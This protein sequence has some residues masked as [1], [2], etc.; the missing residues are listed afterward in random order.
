[1]RERFQVLSMQ[2][3]KAEAD[4][5]VA[6][7]QA[8]MTAGSYTS[9]AAL[10]SADAYLNAQQEPLTKMLEALMEAQRT[11]P[12]DLARPC[13]QL[14]NRLRLQQNMIVQEQQKIRKGR[15]EAER[16]EKER[17]LEQ[18]DQLQLDE[19]LPE[20]TAKAN[21]AEDAA[22]K[23]VITSELVQAA[24][25]DH[26]EAMQ[27]V[28]Q[29]EQ[30]VAEA[31]RQ[32]AEAR[33][34]F[35][36]KHGV[37]RQMGSEKARVRAQAELTK[38]IGQLQEAQMKIKPLVGLRQALQQRQQAQ[39]MVAEVMEKL[40][41]AKLEC[42][43]AEE[44]ANA[45]G[46]G[47]NSDEAR[48]TMDTLV[49]KAS[50]EIAAVM[51]LIAQKKAHATGL[52]VG[53]LHKLEEQ[54]KQAADRMTALKSSYKELAEK[55]VWQG[56][57]RDA[58]GRVHTVQESVS[59]AADAEGPF[60]LG[61]DELPLDET[62]AALRDCESSA[63]IA[64]T[65]AS[66]TK[67]FI[68]TKLVDAKR[69]P[70]SISQEISTKLKQLQGQLEVHTKRLNDLKAKTAERKKVALMR[71]AEVLVSALEQLTTKLSEAAL[72][73]TDAA[74]MDSLAPPEAKKVKDQASKAEG[75]ASVALAKARAFV[76]E[77]QVEARSRSTTS[78]E[79]AAALLKLSARVSTAQAE[80]TKWQR[81][82]GAREE[83]ESKVR[84][85]TEQAKAA[86]EKVSLAKQAV[87][88][89]EAQ[90]VTA[91][92][93][94]NADQ[95][96]NAANMA[97]R[98]ARQAV[99][100]LASV[101]EEEAMLLQQGL[102]EQQELLDAANAAKKEKQGSFLAQ[103][104]LAE[105]EK[106]V[107]DM[108]QSLARAT[109]LDAEHDQA[110][111]SGDGS[112]R[113]AMQR[114]DEAARAATA[115][116]SKTRSF[117]A[118]KRI[119]VKRM[120]PD[121]MESSSKELDAME[122]R[123]LQA[124]ERVTALNQRV[125]VKRRADA[126]AVAHAAPAPEPPSKRGRV[127]YGKPA[128]PPPPPGMP[129]YGAPVTSATTSKAPLPRPLPK[130]G[131]LVQPSK[132]GTAELKMSQVYVMK[133]VQVEDVSPE[134]IRL[135]G[136]DLGV[137][138]GERPRVLALAPG[139]ELTIQGVEAGDLLCSID[140]RE[141]RGVPQHDVVASLRH[142]TCLHFGRGQA[143]GLATSAK[144]APHARPPPPPSRGGYSEYPAEGEEMA[145]EQA[146]EWG[147]AP[148]QQP[149]WGEEQGRWGQEEG[150][151]GE[152][153]QP[154]SV[155]PRQPSSRRQVPSRW[156]EERPAEDRQAEA[157]GRSRDDRWADRRDDWRDQ[158]WGEERPEERRDEERRRSRGQ[159]DEPREEAPREDQQRRSGWDSQ[160]TP[161]APQESGWNGRW[162]SGDDAQIQEESDA[163]RGW[164]EDGDS[165]DA[166][167]ASY[168]GFAP[169]M[170]RASSG[171]PPPGRLPM[172]KAKS[173]AP[174]PSASGSMPMPSSRDKAPL[175]APTIA[176]SKSAGSGP[177]AASLLLPR[178]APKA[179]LP[180]A[181]PK[182]VGS[183]DGRSAPTVPKS[184]S[185]DGAPTL[186]KSKSAGQAPTVPKSSIFPRR[187][188]G[189]ADRRTDPADSKEY[190][191]DELKEKY[192]NSYSPDE[193]Q[194]YWDSEMW[195]PRTDAAPAVETAYPVDSQ[196]DPREM[197]TQDG[198]MRP[199]GEEDMELEDTRP[200]A[201][202]RPT[203]TAAPKSKSK[204]APSFSSGPKAAFGRQW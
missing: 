89:L 31:G 24:G 40:A 77:R 74:R 189:A 171:S 122:S 173:K 16:F 153:H 164:E 123:L 91:A 30:A 76:H 78:A 38:L 166:R 149:R 21:A 116:V 168:G 172:P 158:R 50:G 141:T 106:Q 94:K 163:Q 187:P 98:S 28:E 126:A 14:A 60:L 99:E 19:M 131:G 82:T 185:G 109:D 151:W 83:V 198:G 59:K 183:Y 90:G 84:Q 117:L 45:V 57:V 124:T 145:E 184:G 115:L 33:A 6:L 80:V 36:A 174:M 132:A 27:A 204:A 87:D 176:K 53:E 140:G 47:E 192:V 65:A 72:P 52:V 66:T 150:R 13:V 96:L 17:A 137:A 9:C 202:R 25:D 186:A 11:F 75:K 177:G 134:V 196:R 157:R 136:C 81:V 203:P 2:A 144:S 85:A 10:E 201:A 4:V 130:A 3:T 70:A 8:Q 138:E 97:M 152:Q 49:K 178:A 64:N 58:T 88:E 102:R 44:V 51:Q 170:P 55:A 160:Q 23:A 125:T 143:A 22:E 180:V 200:A 127:E 133:P 61:V 95:A 112:A 114:L 121:T 101:D 43:R 113:P 128:P 162:G 62:L 20:A 181:N 175:P 135:S 147:A 120:A 46:A 199:D 63:A 119:A 34:F 103:S 32:I 35:N 194:A 15:V 167:G 118:M 146:P 37:V 68:M 48:A 154:Q 92:Q 41:P 86:E 161:Q 29:T 142:S 100:T 148:S 111:E 107:G 5:K 155:P 110:T 197:S 105:V 93:V 42:D 165:R 104:I 182:S 56:V 71:E 1:M 26:E 190:T 191:F 7:Q 69:L 139:S 129:P 159:W 108:E 193:I 54:A 12:P 18:Q 67:M 195:T 73:L 169:S 179:M 156:G 188:V 79:S 39:Q